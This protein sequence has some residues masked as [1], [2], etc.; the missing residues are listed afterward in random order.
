MEELFKTKA[1]PLRGIALCKCAFAIFGDDCWL[2]A[3]FEAT[4]WGEQ[5][6]EE[7][8]LFEDKFR[9]VPLNIS[10]FRSSSLSPNNAS[11]FVAIKARL[12]SAAEND[13]NLN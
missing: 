12:E 5:I 7:G 1:L 3:P 8:E 11:D 10:S 4:L 6:W 9:R 13:G 2:V